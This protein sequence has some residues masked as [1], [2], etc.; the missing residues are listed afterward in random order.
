MQ[1]KGKKD[2]LA[3]QILTTYILSMHGFFL[4]QIF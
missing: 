1:E 4:M 2:D 3:K